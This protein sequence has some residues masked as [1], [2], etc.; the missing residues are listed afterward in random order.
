MSATEQD[1]SSYAAL[2]TSLQATVSTQGGLISGNAQA[3][4]QLVARADI[5]DGV[6][7]TTASS[8]QALQTTQ[9]GHTATLTTYGTS[10]DGV[11][12][13][14]GVTGY[15]DGATGGFVLTGARQLDGS[16]SFNLNISADVFVDG[17]ITARKLAATELIVNSAQIGD[18]IVSTRSIGL[19]QV[20]NMVGGV[21]TTNQCD[22][23]ITTR[24]GSQVAIIALA[25][26]APTAEL[27]SGQLT[28][29]IQLVKDDSTIMIS[30]PNPSFY[31]GSGDS[32]RTRVLTANI[33]GFDAP[34]EGTHKYSCVTSANLPGVIMLVM[35]MAR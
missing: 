30:I 14:Y 12:V 5:V 24:A 29:D 13:Q 20:S 4:Q 21:S 25:I 3:T 16:V 9:A 6:L 22:V 32:R 31:T 11:K 34:S 27:P 28:G 7:S 19:R 18:L 15:I 8:I 17:T 1:V 35:E 26:N 33:I 10:I 2:L 23:S